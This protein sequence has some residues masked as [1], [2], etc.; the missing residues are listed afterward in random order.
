MT[1]TTI[2]LLVLREEAEI[3][4][5]NLRNRLNCGCGWCQTWSESSFK[6]MMTRLRENEL[7]IRKVVDKSIGGKETDEY[8]YLI[9]DKGKAFI[10]NELSKLYIS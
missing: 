10:T 3:S 9:T 2:I 5:H 4:A 7:V 1:H 8:R 6:K